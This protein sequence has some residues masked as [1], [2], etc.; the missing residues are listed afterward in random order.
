VNCAIRKISSNG[1]VTTLAGNGNPGFVNGLGTNATFNRPLGVAVDVGGNV[2]VADNCAIRKISSNGLVTT[3]AG[4]MPL[5][6]NFF[7]A[8]GVAVDVGGNVYVVDS[9]YGAISKISSNGVV[10]TLAGNVNLNPGFVNGLGTN[11]TFSYLTGVAVDVGG[12]VYVADSENCAIRKLTPL[13][14]KASN[15]ITFVQPSTR[16]YSNGATFALSATAPGGTVTFTSG[17]TNVITIYGSTATIKGSG[18]SVITANQAGNS[19][20]LAATPVTKSVM[21]NKAAQNITFTPITPITLA[22]TKTFTLSGSS[23]SGLALT[24]TSSATNVISI[25]GTTAT[26][27]TKGTTTLTALQGGN[28]NYNAATAVPRSVTVQ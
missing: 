1:V 19:N 15:P 26:V 12:N 3:L 21:V 17:N 23:T 16:T 22:T 10:T 6:G 9:G 20:Y 27:K 18:S 2:Y 14:A 8:Y 4:A 25:S 11:A 28:D 24:Y 5:P 7:M 13:Y